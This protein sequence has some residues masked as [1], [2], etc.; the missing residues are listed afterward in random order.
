MVDTIVRIDAARCSGCGRCISACDLR[1]FA[2]ETH[3]WKKRSVLHDPQRCTGCG[4]CGARCAT[5]A[6]VMAA[7]GLQDVQPDGH[8][9]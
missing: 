3:D 9:R 6:I 7:A 1:L 2:F 8:R 5:G 4:E